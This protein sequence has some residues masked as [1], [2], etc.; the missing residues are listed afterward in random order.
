M[1]ST[2]ESSMYDPLMIVK[3]NIWRKY[4][5]IE[6][7]KYNVF[8]DSYKPKYGQWMIVKKNISRNYWKIEGRKYIML[9]ILQ[10]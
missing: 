6:G 1:E 5:S 7:W 2:C 8:N 9:L 3:R 10:L 4:W